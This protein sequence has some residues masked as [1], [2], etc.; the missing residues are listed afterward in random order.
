MLAT[1]TYDDRLDTGLKG[2]AYVEGWLI[3]LDYLTNRFSE[4]SKT[5]NGPRL[6][7]K[8]GIS[9]ALPDILAAKNLKVYP[10]SLP[11]VA[12]VEVKWRWQFY[13]DKTE[14]EWLVGIDYISWDDYESIE[15]QT[16]LK[17]WLLFLSPGGSL[18]ECPVGLL[19]QTL[20][21]L[22]QQPFYDREIKGR[23]CRCFSEKSL[24]FMDDYR[25]VVEATPYAYRKSGTGLYTPTNR[26][27]IAYDE[28]PLGLVSS[29]A[30]LIKTTGDP[31]FP[32]P[33]ETL[34]VT[35]Y[36][37]FAEDADWFRRNAF[38]INR[39]ERERRGWAQ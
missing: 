8:D 20:E 36:G 39:R 29:P 26:G 38:D 11:V 37:I 21:E 27:S 23:P 17:T 31:V 3:E 1:R 7:G 34:H 25:N 5:G 18:P 24:L 16:G 32:E 22:K 19:G 6:R 12:Y 14:R 9:Y 33:A 4:I 15:D 13:Y 35:P 28:D 10:S 30:R 2:E